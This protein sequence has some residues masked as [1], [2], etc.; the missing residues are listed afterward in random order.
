VSSLLV[1]YNP[2]STFAKQSCSLQCISVALIT[3]DR[4]I[5]AKCSRL[6]VATSSKLL[7]QFA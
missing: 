3:K 6:S 2:P 1:W 4:L 5:E 7:L